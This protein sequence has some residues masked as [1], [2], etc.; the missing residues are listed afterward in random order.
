MKSRA[1]TIA[2]H[3]ARL[4]RTQPW[5]VVILIVIPGLL[6]AFF[7]NGIVGGAA[8][9]VPGVAALF[10]FFGLSAIGL[11]FFRDH[12]WMT[13]DRLRVSRARPIA[14]IFGKLTPLAMVF[15]AQYLLLFPLSWAAFGLQIRG[16]V[17]GVALVSVALVSVEL[18]IGL[19]LAV[20]CTSIAQL[21]TL[22]SVGA[23]LL[24]GG[25]GALAPIETFPGWL[26][27]I[28]PVSPV[29]WSFKGFY[30]AIGEG[31]SLND[32]LG[33]IAVLFGMAAVCFVLSGVFYKHEQR[34]TF[35]A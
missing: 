33:P 32:V 23:L 4:M 35:F 17:L 3:E 20:V 7:A 13:W 18:G 29:Y 34:K 28:A 25:A 16:S 30:A 8:R 26:Q 1:L 24:V 31:G 27:A 12:G 11:A 5:I 10:G 14:V 19:L 9:A 6:L 15:L 21:N 2:R 22:V